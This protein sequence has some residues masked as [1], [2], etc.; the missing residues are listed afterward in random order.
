MSATFCDCGLPAEVVERFDL[1]DSDGQ[2]VPHVVTACFAHHKRTFPA[3][4]LTEE[5]PAE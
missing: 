4:Y 2:P 1:S 5:V 3:S